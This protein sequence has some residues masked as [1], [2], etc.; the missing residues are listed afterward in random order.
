MSN[1][2]KTRNSSKSG[3][4]DGGR[5]NRGSARNKNLQKTIDE[6]NK[7]VRLNKYIADCGLTSRRKADELIAAGKVKIN[8]KTVLE[9]GA[10]VEKGDF[11]TVNGDPISADRVHLKYIL[12]NKPKDTITTTNDEMRRKTVMDIVRSRERIYPVG[13]LDRN[14]TGVL[15]ITNDGELANRLMHPRH[16][17]ERTYNATLDKELTMDIA[18]KIADGVE[19]EDGKTSPCNVFMYPEDKHKVSVTLREGKNR[20]VRRLFEHFHYKVKKLDRKYFANLSTAGL[21]RGQYRAITQKE[22]RELRSMVGL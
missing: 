22:I 7:A 15:I 9:M 21:K 14:T 12:L 17:I 16:R 19:L 2:R 1:F 13:R 6:S 18:Q 5:K 8:R 10:K 4:K 20:E 11:V 3:S